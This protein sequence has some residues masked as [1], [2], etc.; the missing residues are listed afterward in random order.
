[1]NFVYEHR[2]SH[3][4]SGHVVQRLRRVGGRLVPD[5][6]VPARVVRPRAVRGA[7]ELVVSFLIGLLHLLHVLLE[8]G[9]GCRLGCLVDVVPP[10]LR[11]RKKESTQNAREVRVQSL[12]RLKRYIYIYIYRYLVYI[13]IYFLA[14][15]LPLQSY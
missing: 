11:K 2:C 6:V 13:Y 4:S 10:T 9:L 3:L 12:Y 5:H 1:M 14:G 8:A 15:I 7:D